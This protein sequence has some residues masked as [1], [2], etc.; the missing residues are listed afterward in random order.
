MKRSQGDKIL[1]DLKR[2]MVFLSGPRQVGKS[3]LARELA[4]Q[5]EKPLYLNWDNRQDREILLRQ[6]WPGESDLLVF[7]EIHKMPDWK[8]YLKGGYIH[9]RHGERPAGDVQ[10]VRRQPRR[11]IFPS[12]AAA[13]KPLRGDA[14]R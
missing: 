8:N 11:T 10:A 13:D 5:F 4:S 9:P 2:K 12:Q 1:T 7:D 14:G 3:W 6:A